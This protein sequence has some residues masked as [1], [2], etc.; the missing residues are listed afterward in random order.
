M[1][2]NEWLG[3]IGYAVAFGILV[4]VAVWKGIDHVNEWLRRP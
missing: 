3:L 4:A 2:G 1:N